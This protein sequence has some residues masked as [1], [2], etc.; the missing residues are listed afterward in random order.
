MVPPVVTHPQSPLGN[1]TPIIA[2]FLKFHLEQELLMHKHRLKNGASIEAAKEIMS[3]AKIFLC[4][5]SHESDGK[6]QNRHFPLSIGLISEFIK[7]NIQDV[8]TFLFKRPSL[9]GSTLE[10]IAPDI[11]MFGNYMWNEKLNCFFAKC[12]KSIYPKTLIVFG[13]PNIS[14][15]LEAN[16]EFLRT[17][18][19]IDML[20]MGDGEIVSKNI[21]SSHIKA[22][23]DIEKTK[24]LKIE[25]TL[26]ISTRSNKTIQGEKADYRIGVGT[27]S[28]DSIPSPYLSGAM[29]VFFEDAGIPLLE[30]N[31]GCPYACSFCQQGDKYFSKIRHHDDQR[32]KSELEYVAKKINNSDLK[33]A[34][35]EFADPNFGMYKRDTNIFEHIRFVQD[36]YNYPSDV[37][38][39]T[40]KSQHDLIVSNAKILKEG[41]IMIRAAMQSMNESTLKNIKRKNLPIEVFKKMS[42]DGV[43]TYSDIMLGLPSETKETYFRGIFDLIDSGIDEFSMPQTIILKGT[44]MEEKEYV[45][46]FDLKTQFRVIPECN[47]VYHVGDF[48]SRV[49]ETESIVRSTSTLTF[50]DYLECRKLN[51]LVMIFHNTRLLSPLYSYLDYLNI[52]RS[53]I[54]SNIISKIQNSGSSINTILDNYIE[55]TINELSYEDLAFDTGDNIEERSSNKLYK[56][57]TLSLFYYKSEIIALIKDILHKIVESEQHINTMLNIVDALIME[58][59]SVSEHVQEISLDEEMKKVMGGEIAMVSH[60][61]LQKKKLNILKDIYVSKQD[62]ENKLAYHLRPIHMIKT[63]RFI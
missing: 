9:L 25:N 46:E 2:F 15:N 50:D 4:L 47:G 56:Y 55:D 5:L 43:D 13:G 58:D 48:S 19:F 10:N 21:V 32:I 59:M 6:L 8:D 49:V 60:S 22:N 35:I 44:P 42:S 31:R 14:S 38:C 40:G 53:S 63:L 36:T 26:S 57:L 51:L 17:N 24:S 12:I 27:V 61:D 33:M 37:W 29:D 3:T 28:L 52:D 23:K 30:T 16:I 1:R 45:K 62:I 20:A 11:V 54:L 18:Q 41:S 39:S 34:T 7:Q